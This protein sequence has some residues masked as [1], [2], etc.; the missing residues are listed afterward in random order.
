[1]AMSKQDYI[2]LG[3]S[4]FK[5]GENRPLGNSWQSKAM[6]QGYDCAQ[7]DDNDTRHYAKLDAQNEA[8][9][10]QT[11]DDQGGSSLK[12]SEALPASSQIDSI[13]Y[14][15]TPVRN[16]ALRDAIAQVDS[17]TNAITSH[18]AFLREEAMLPTTSIKRATR[19]IYKA[20][21]LQYK[22]QYLIG[23]A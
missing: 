1:M 18:I 5:R 11:Q 2:T 17:T 4:Q 9:S 19:L 8:A 14:H 22:H 21:L 10:A 3:E 6:Q 13:G 7:T 23:Q 20:D 16:T 12:A 15:P